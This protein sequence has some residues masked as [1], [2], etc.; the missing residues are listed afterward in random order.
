MIK[1]KLKAF[2]AH[3]YLNNKLIDLPYLPRIA[4]IELTNG[5]NYQCRFCA[6]NGNNKSIIKKINRKKNFMNYSDF[7]RLVSKYN[8]L[9][10]GVCISHHGESLLHPDF[11]KFVRLLHENNI[12]CSIT[13]NGSCLVV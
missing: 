2:L 5:C 8:K 4:N 11:S 9:M 3:Y 1:S 13:T 6:S 12:N 7:F 10:D